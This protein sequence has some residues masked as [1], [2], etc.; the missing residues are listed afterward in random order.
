MGAFFGVIAALLECVVLGWFY[1]AKKLRGHINEVSSLKVSLWWDYSIK[2]VIPV[3]LAALVLSTLREDFTP[4]YYE[5]YP[6]ISLIVIG[7]DWLIFTLFAA[8]I[9]SARKWAGPKNDSHVK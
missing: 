1:Q 9:I 2:F 6:V 3:V 4:P 7:R 5:N 8:I